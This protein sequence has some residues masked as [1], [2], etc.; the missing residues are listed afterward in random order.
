MDLSF[1]CAVTLQE[2][3]VDAEAIAIFAKTQQMIK[4]VRNA[5]A[6]TSH[7]R[8]PKLLTVTLIS[9]E[10]N[11][12]ATKKTAAVIYSS[13]GN[14]L[15]YLQSEIPMISLLGRVFAIM[16]AVDVMVS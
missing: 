13:D 10:Y 11:V 12:D 9:S 6:G 15:S 7:C 2:L 8:M 5:R 3:M 4:A 16:T 14:Y 1:V